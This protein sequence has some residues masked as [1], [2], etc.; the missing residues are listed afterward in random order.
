MSRENYF[1]EVIE[2]SLTGWLA[3]SWAWDRFPEF[4]SFVAIEG[5]KRTVFGIV[6]QVQTGS[7]DPVRYPFPYQKTEEELLKEQPQIFEFLKTTFSCITVGYQEKKSISYL[8]APE[9]PKIHAFITHPSAE[10]SKI[11]F[12]STRYMHL[13]FTHASQIF[14]MD[15]LMLALLK[16]HIDLNILTKDKIN[17]F[18]QTYSLLTGNDYRRLKLFLQ[19]AEHMLSNCATLEF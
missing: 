4:G 13:L 15:E 6:H 2:S 7:M 11:F 1:A 16:Q 18:M 17:S 8:V 12:A 10:L 9:P 3:Q 14:N 5:K 19:R